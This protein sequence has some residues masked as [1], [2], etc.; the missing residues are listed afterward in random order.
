[1]P[2]RYPVRFKI[3]LTMLAVITAVMGIITYFMASRFHDDKMTY[4][5]DLASIVA[6]NT[7]EES[8]SILLGYGERLQGYARIL[9]EKNLSPEQKRMMFKELF[10]NFRDFLAV[11][12]YEHGK[13]QAAIVDV[14]ALKASGLTKK[15][16]LAYWKKNPPA[17]EN[18]GDKGVSIERLPVS[19]EVQAFTMTITYPAGNGGATGVLEAIFRLDGLLRI[20]GR[21]RLFETFLVTDGGVLLA[22]SNPKELAQK[23]VAGW[24]PK[25]WMIQSGKTEAT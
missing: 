19:D 6:L 15:E 4:L 20:T 11:T 22:H 12:I 17:F 21:S 5:H 24:I 23:P 18:F 10:Q 3:L 16:I 1:M 9:H 13:E 2:F 14:E 25:S 8:N 7:A